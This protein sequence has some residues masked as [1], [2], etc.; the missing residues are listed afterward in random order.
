MVDLFAL[1]EARINAQRPLPAAP[2]GDLEAGEVTVHFHTEPPLTVPAYR[3]GALAVHR[4]VTTPQRWGVSHAGTGRLIRAFDDLS[5]AVACAR[6]A[7][8]AIDWSQ[9]R[10]GHT[11]EVLVGWTPE[12]AAQVMAAIG[13]GEANG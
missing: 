4:T 5:A 3:L 13:P 8:Q 2:P 7:A 12:L 1:P 6:K 10:A 9:L 11:P